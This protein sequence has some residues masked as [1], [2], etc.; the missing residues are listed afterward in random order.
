MNGELHKTVISFKSFSINN[1]LKFGDKITLENI[2][3]VRKAIKRQ[4]PSIFFIGLH[5]Q[6]TYIGM[7]LAGLLVIIL[8]FQ[9]LD[10]HIWSFYYKS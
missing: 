3:K 1:I 8:T 7:K 6:E 10:A 2:L 5:F 9:F 4:V